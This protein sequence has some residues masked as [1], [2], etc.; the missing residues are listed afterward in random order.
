MTEIHIIGTGLVSCLGPDVETTWQQVLAGECGFR[1]LD[2]FP[3]DEF[4]QTHGG[5][6]PDT[7]ENELREALPDEDLAFAMVIQAAREAVSD[8]EDAGDAG[9]VLATN[10]GLMETREWCWRER[11]DVNEMDEATFNRQQDVIANVAGALDLSGPTAQLSLSCASGA[12]A[13]ALARQ[14]LR[15][16]RCRRVLCICYDALTE[17]CWC[18]LSNLHTITDDKLRPFDVTRHGTIFSEGAAAL[19]LSADPAD[20]GQS[21]ARLLGAATNNNAFH[22]TAPAKDADG[23]RRV[24]AAALENAG[25]TA[26][27][28]DLISAHATGTSANDVTEA[29]AINSLLDGRRVPVAGLKSSFGHMLGA[30]GLA[31]ILMVVRMLQNGVIPAVVNLDEQDPECDLDVVTDNRSGAYQA[32]ATNS[33]GI[34][35]NNAATVIGSTSCRA[36]PPPAVD[37]PVAV[38]QAGWVLPGHCGHGEALP[39]VDPA[40]LLGRNDALAEFS[41]KEYIH[42]VKGYLDPAGKFALAAA[43]LCLDD[44][45]PKAVERTAVVSVTQYGATTSA[46]RFFAQMINK[47]HRFASPMIFPHSY[48][49]TAGNLV[50]IEFGLAGPHLVFDLAPDPSEAWW[51]AVDLIRSGAADDV[52]LVCY[53]GVLDEAVPDDLDVVNGAIAVRLGSA[54][55]GADAAAATPGL[56]ANRH[57]TV[58]A[59]LT[60]LR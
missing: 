6:L 52:L 37:R 19:L 39:D 47:G 34:G 22:L 24:L 36:Q 59:A 46:Y 18:G 26:V 8:V 1:P 31:E 10:F 49:N 45:L 13:V 60:S 43:A 58:L 2:R 7:V 12:G 15:A 33:A 53:E 32:A 30:A 55:G 17:Y 20:A 14:W 21:Q 57:G 42:S 48:S 23:S 16:G 44:D 9:L 35:G 25:L 4:P 29:A 11:V 50:A 51:A 28:V 41:V 3:L 54:G 27:Q 56:P 40:D 38:R 5:Q